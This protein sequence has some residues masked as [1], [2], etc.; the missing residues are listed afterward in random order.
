[1]LR[2][3]GNARNKQDAAWRQFI[4]LHEYKADLYG[5]HVVQV[6][7]EGTFVRDST[8]G[9]TPTDWPKPLG[10]RQTV[11]P[12]VCPRPTCRPDAWRG[13]G[14]CDQ[15]PRDSFAPG[16]TVPSPLCR[17]GADTTRQPTDGG[18]TTMIIIVNT[19]SLICNRLMSG[20]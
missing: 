8:L 12:Q 18:D 4:T 2:G 14:A 9:S 5:C 3:D 6:E 20:R 17:R 13:R 16:E 1:M 15:Y 7:P 10:H 11:L 19:I